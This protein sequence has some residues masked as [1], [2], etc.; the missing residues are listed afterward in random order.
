MWTGRLAALD[1]VGDREDLAL[2]GTFG[3]SHARIG[4][5]LFVFAAGERDDGIT[6]LELLPD[7]SLIAVGSVFDSPE[8]ALDDVNHFAT[9]SINGQTFLYADA[10]Q[11]H[12]ITVFRVEADGTLSPV[13][14]VYDDPETT[15]RG[16]IGEM[17]IV[18]IG[19]ETY[20]LATGEVDHGVTTFRIDSQ[21]RLSAAHAVTD[22]LFGRNASLGG[23]RGVTT[24][25]VDG[26]EFA[27]VA[28]FQ[29]SGLAVFEM[30]GQGQL[31]HHWSTFDAISMYFEL[32]G[33]I[34]VAS[35]QIGDATYVFGAGAYDDGISAFQLGANGRLTLVWSVSDGVGSSTLNGAEVLET[36]T[37]S[38]E[39]FL[40]VAAYQ[41]SAVTVFH[42]DENGRMTELTTLRDTVATKFAG[43]AGLSVDVHEGRV[44]LFAGGLTDNGISALELGGGDN[45]LT[46]TAA[47]ELS[48][49]FAGNDR[50]I[51]SPGADTIAGGVGHDVLSYAS[52]GAGVSVDLG[53]G[54]GSGGDAEGDV[55]REIEVLV[56]SA[57][58]DILIGGADS[59]WLLGEGGDDFLFADG[60]TG[61]M[62]A[63]EVSALLAGSAMP[64][65]SAAAFDIELSPEPDP[66]FGL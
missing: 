23:A 22:D 18:S 54:T 66:F 35:A 39:T 19:S 26:I 20:L 44:L 34:D 52:S 64:Q 49:G 40:A 42:V 58:G 1:S 45:L 56:G 11:D 12:G 57:H 7:N 27:I 13:Q 25:T 41:D 31:T 14:I 33:V 50:I 30:D 32:N 65:A 21:G 60:S 29:E 2:D 24:A 4:D 59:D 28:G 53:K 36:F 46:G 6:I 5:R 3:V 8:V 17:A 37:T 61:R 63:S 9:I 48:F 15:L 55:I 47:D 16:T 51:G 62:T 43:T 38:G 10:Q